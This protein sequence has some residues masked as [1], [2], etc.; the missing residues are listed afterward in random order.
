[1]VLAL[2]ACLLMTRLSRRISLEGAREGIEAFVRR[3]ER[4]VVRRS[5]WGLAL[6][7]VLGLAAMTRNEA[8]WLALTFALIEWGNAR[9]SYSR[10]SDR[11]GAWAIRVIPVGF[12]AFE[13]FLPWAYRDW[14]AFGT[15]FPGQALTNALSLDGRDIFAWQ[16]PPTLARYLAAGLGKLVELRWVGT[17]HN[18]TQVLLLLGVPLSL[19]GLFGLF[20]MVRRRPADSSAEPDPLRPLLIFSV[21]TFLV[22]SLVFPVST[23]WGTFLH[24]AGAIHVLLVISALLV[25]D[26][27]I[28]WVGRRRGWTRPVAWLGPA[29]AIAGCLLFS[30]VILPADGR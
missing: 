14:V 19:L 18:L 8:L 7:V 17:L 16:S 23:T 5:R 4:A 20:P 3:T 12:F 10:W 15:P 11:F 29:F 26:A 13:V 21:I 27:L 2:L 28:V 6:A 25:L 1:A 30:A 24:A 22:A 9:A